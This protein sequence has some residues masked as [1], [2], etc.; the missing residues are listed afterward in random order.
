MGASNP[1]NQLEPNPFTSAEMQ[2][3][4]AAIIKKYDAVSSS[5][6]GYFSYPVG[7]EGALRLG[8]PKELLDEMAEP[9]LNAFCG[10]GNPLQ[11]EQIPEGGHVLD[12]GCGAGFDLYIASR[13]VGAAGRV[14][15]VDLSRAMAARARA[16]LSVLQVANFAIVEVASETLPFPGDTFERVTSNGVINL[17]PDKAGLFAEIHRVLK[18][19]GLLQFADIILDKELPAHL[20]SGVESWS[21]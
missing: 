16:N 15:G 3:I 18:P 8:Y 13:M 2:Q 17:S 6:T 19:G 11:G 21:Q 12:I 20:A 14:V 4:R 10:V 5:A 9:L 1:R 7:K